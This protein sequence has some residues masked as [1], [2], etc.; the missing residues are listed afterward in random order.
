MQSSQDLDG[1][2]LEVRG[3]TLRDEHALPKNAREECTDYRELGEVIRMREDAEEASEGEGKAGVGSA[4]GIE[5]LTGRARGDSL[6]DGL[7][8][9]HK[10]SLSP[11]DPGVPTDVAVLEKDLVE[12]D[13][14]VASSKRGIVSDHEHGQQMASRGMGVDILCE[15]E[16]VARDVRGIGRPSEAG[17]REGAPVEASD[18][19]ERKEGEAANQD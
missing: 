12:R 19:G 10:D 1:R 6:V 8:V 18:E 4:L 7:V 17:R 5:P 9:C 2:L 13:P 11:Y 3:R 15:V 14:C 16:E